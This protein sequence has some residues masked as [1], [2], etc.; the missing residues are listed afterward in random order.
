[1]GD[2]IVRPFNGRL[3]ARDA[4]PTL[5]RAGASHPSRSLA[6]TRNDA[7]QTMLRAL[8]TRNTRGGRE[9]ICYADLEV[10]QLGAVYERVLDVEPAASASCARPRRAPAKSA[11]HSDRRKEAGTFY[12]PQSLCDFVVRRTLAPLIS[13]RSADGILALRVVDPA[14]GSGAFLVAACR[15]LA[16]AYPGEPGQ[17]GASANPTSTTASGRTSAG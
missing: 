4:A 12:T 8:A 7:T 1:M 6:A 10:N 13:G 14:M 9:E 16:C 2:L 17:E 15:Y 11:R 3:F 5:E